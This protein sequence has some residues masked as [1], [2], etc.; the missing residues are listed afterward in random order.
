MLEQ[1]IL[2]KMTTFQFDFTVALKL[3]SEKLNKIEIE[4]EIYFLNRS[5][6]FSSIKSDGPKKLI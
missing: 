2:A 1:V 4:F 6:H 3:I 5:K